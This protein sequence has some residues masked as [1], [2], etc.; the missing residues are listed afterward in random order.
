MKRVEVHWDDAAHYK[1][2]KD[3]QEI[4]E[5]TVMKCKSMGYLTR[6]GKKLVCVSQE[7]LEDGRYRDTDVIPRC[8]VTKIVVLHEH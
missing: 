4:R 8:L 2:A 5:L 7:A 3:L 6:K 1:D